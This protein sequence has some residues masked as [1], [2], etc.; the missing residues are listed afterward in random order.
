MKIYSIKT[1]KRKIL[2]VCLLMS[3]IFI[4]PGYTLH[5]FNVGEYNFIGRQYCVENQSVV[6]NDYKKV[7]ADS[8]ND[9][10]RDTIPPLSFYRIVEESLGGA[11]VGAA[12]A[13]GTYFI[14]VTGADHN[15]WGGDCGWAIISMDIGWVLGNQFGAY[16]GGNIGEETGSLPKTLIYG[17]AI[18]LGIQALAFG[19]QYY[20][21]SNIV[22]GPSDTPIFGIIEVSAPII[23]AVVGFNLTRR[24]KT[25]QSKGEGLI[26]INDGKLS[27][28]F[29]KLFGGS[30]EQSPLV[31]VNLVNLKF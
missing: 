25:V 1:V 26:S 20:Y 3:S 31:G 30:I 8:M 29:P 12:G 22:D 21:T 19:S 5:A 28:D 15:I 9:T 18:S 4:I 16:I 10:L 13:I 7:N 23:G 2:F 17:T 24:Y 27:F 14:Y 11:F 6:Y